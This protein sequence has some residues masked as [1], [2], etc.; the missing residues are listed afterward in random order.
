MDATM[1]QSTADADTPIELQPDSKVYLDDEGDVWIKFTEGR[2]TSQIKV[3]M[4][5]AQFVEFLIKA[6][7]VREAI[8]L[9][10]SVAAQEAK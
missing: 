6:D 7:R 1:I 3:N 9:R 10:M 5:P 4:S 2:W 8:E